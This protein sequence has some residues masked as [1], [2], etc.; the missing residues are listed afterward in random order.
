MKSNFI[1]T[2]NSSTLPSSPP[3]FKFKKFHSKLIKKHSETMKTLQKYY[4]TTKPE[5]EYYFKFSSRL[6]R[7]NSIEGSSPIKQKKTKKIKQNKN[8]NRK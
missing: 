3:K 1:N 8:F 7:R 2:K 4:E 5:L 6:R